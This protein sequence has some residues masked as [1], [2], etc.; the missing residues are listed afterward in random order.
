MDNYALL[1]HLATVLLV[2]LF[3]AFILY[4]F[5]PSKTMIN[6]PFKGLNLNLTGAFG[7][8]FLLVLVSIGL[9]HFVLNNQLTDELKS[10]ENIINGLNKQIAELNSSIAKEKNKYHAWKMIGAL[11]SN[12]PETPKIFIDEENISINSLGKFKA[13][14]VVKIGDDNKVKLPDAVCFFNKGEGYSVIDLTQKQQATIDTS[15][16]EIKIND[17]VKFYSPNRNGASS[18][19]PDWK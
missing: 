2:P 8:Y 12:S 16:N 1:L 11:D 18:K 3:P 9:T 14:L 15:I 4:K 6:G 5:L 10:S 17:V 19:D 13:N 7:G